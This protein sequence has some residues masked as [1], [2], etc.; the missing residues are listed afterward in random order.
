M[1]ESKRSSRRGFLKSSAILTGAAAL[2]SG[3]SI[4]RSAHAAGSDELKVALV[5]CGGRGTGAAENCLKVNDNLKLVAVADAF[6][7]RTKNALKYLRERFSDRVDVTDDRTFVGLDAYQKAI[8]A[9]DVVLLCTPPGFRPTHYAAAVK[10]SK[11]IFMEKPLCTDAPGYLSVVESNKQADEKNLKV[12]V[13]LQRHHEPTWIK[14]IQDIHDGKLGD[15]LFFRVYWNGGNSEDLGVRPQNAKDELAFQL[16]HWNSFRWLYGDNIVEQHVHNIDIAN[17]AMCKD[18]DWTKA[19]PVEANGMGA[20]TAK[21]NTGD[22]FD[23]HFVEFTYENG[24]KMFS[25]A[26][27]VP[28]C[29]E[30]VEEFAHGT[31]GSSNCRDMSVKGNNPYDQEH[32]DLIEAIRKDKK[33]NGGWYGAVSSMTAI[34]GRMA[35]YSGQVVRW[36]DAVKGP[37][38]SPETIAWDAPMRSMPGPDGRY[39]YPVPGVYKPF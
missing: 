8:D 29:W 16:R 25:Q 27:H 33:L 22:I 36:D 17:W 38:E 19:H 26:N 24:T 1:S 21:G 10:A 4:S 35:T 15:V 2:S 34:L 18:G 11:N 28:G 13:G 9:A 37:A 39:A 6:E 31:K 30:K 3:L 14:G 23:H 32:V 5:G 7:D 20:R 12:V